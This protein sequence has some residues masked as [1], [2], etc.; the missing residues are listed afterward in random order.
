MLSYARKLT[1]APGSMTEQDVQ[2]LRN[3]DFTDRGI[4]E[5]NLAAA[6]MNFVNCVAEGLG[7]K[8]EPAL[9]PFTR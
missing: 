1:T 8:L 5:V 2:A 9:D 7:V 4:L 6:Y 3:E